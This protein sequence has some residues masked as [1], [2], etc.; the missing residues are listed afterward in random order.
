MFMGHFAAALVPLA[1]LDKA[2]RKKFFWILL[3]ASQFL[4]FIMLI[5]VALGIETMTPNKYGEVA[6][7]KMQTDMV[8]SHDIVPVLVWIVLFGGV[9]YAVKRN[10]YIA[11]WSAILVAV[12]ELFDLIVGFEHNIF[13]RDTMAV[14]ANLYHKNPVLGLFIE[15]VICSAC[16]I[17]FVKVSEKRNLSVSKSLKMF[18]WV[19]LVGMTLLSIP[20]GSYS[21]A[22]LKEILGF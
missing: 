3:L 8:F 9:V 19:C 16:I 6:L 21:L 17:Y 18:L 20:A 22:E 10:T 4:D 14:G 1:K 12:H 11:I 2:E 7:Y 5:F 15:A 13:G